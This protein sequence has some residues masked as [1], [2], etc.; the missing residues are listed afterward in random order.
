MFPFLIAVIIDL[1]LREPPK[2]IFERM[3]TDYEADFE[4]VI[5][6]EI[7]NRELPEVETLSLRVLNRAFELLPWN[8]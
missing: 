4:N 8:E 3:L 2:E 6:N 7:N 5:S 1:T